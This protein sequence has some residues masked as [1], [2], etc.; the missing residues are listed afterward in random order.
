MSALSTLGLP[1]SAAG[2]TGSLVH[3]QRETGTPP[4]GGTKSFLSVEWDHEPSSQSI[5]DPGQGHEQLAGWDPEP[6]PADGL[7]ITTLEWSRQGCG[8]PSGV[9]GEN[10]QCLL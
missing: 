5:L 1:S 10:Q 8:V 2:T 6:V 9:D 4:S 7:G 3:I